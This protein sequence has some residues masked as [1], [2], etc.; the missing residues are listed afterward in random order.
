MSRTKQ[1]ALGLAESLGRAATALAWH[2]LPSAIAAA[3]AVL[4]STGA[5][6]AVITR[7]LVERALSTQ[8][9]AHRRVFVDIAV[10]RDVEPEVGELPGVELFDLDALQDRLQ[11]R[12]RACMSRGLAFA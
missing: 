5:P 9:G 10:P 11:L 2:D 3:D 4:C 6:H 1:H 7:E 8:G 12:H